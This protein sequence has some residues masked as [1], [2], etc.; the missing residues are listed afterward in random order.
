MGSLFLRTKPAM[1]WFEIHV[2]VVK[3]LP[4]SNVTLALL[5][6]PLITPSYPFMRAEI[7]LVTLLWL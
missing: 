5:L 1:F 6:A 3:L 2:Q 4:A 7:E